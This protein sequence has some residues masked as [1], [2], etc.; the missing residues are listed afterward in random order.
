MRIIIAHERNTIQI[1]RTSE[2]EALTVRFDVRDWPELY[3]AGGSFVLVHQRPGDAQPYV[4][5]ASVALDGYL[6]WIVAAVDVEKIGAG[7]AQLTYVFGETIAK[8][9]IFKTQIQ[10][11]LGQT[12]ELP[13][14]YEDKIDELIEAAGNITTDANRAE[15]ARTGAETAQQKAEQ[16]Q[17]AAETAQG[18]AEQAQAGAEQAKRDTD[19]AAAAALEN[20]SSAKTAAVS[21]VGAAGDAAVLHVQ[22]EGSTQVAAATQQA[23]NAASSA[24]I[25]TQKAGLA[26]GSASA[27]AADAL[28]AE[29]FATGKQN[30]VDVPS[31][32]PYYQNSAEYYKDQAAGSAQAAGEAQTAAETAKE[33]AEDAQEAA[34]QTKEEVDSIVEGI[35]Q[36]QTAL[37]ILGVSAEVAA[38][39]QEIVNL[40]RSV[41]YYDELPEEG[42]AGYV[43]ITP[44]GIFYY[45]G[46]EYISCAGGSGSLNGFS[47]ALDELRRV[48]LS[49]INPEDETDTDSAVLPA[50]STGV[51]IAGVLADINDYLEIIAGG[52][53]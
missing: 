52:T 21:D 20:I 32:S 46:T 22:Q 25:A 8:S 10:R 9:V 1:G 16:A 36:E 23:E 42:T 6:D 19:A 15:T 53:T 12:G 26:A 33:G 13:E 2:N 14:P 35:A 17:E 38:K 50:N 24:G 45:N 48:V 37:Q 7:E 30:G 31:E 28:K 51:E 3:G 4:C 18:K 11:S 34:E 44:D 47:F 39:V 49:Y 29:G 41:R 40:L 5:A 43:Y 27:A